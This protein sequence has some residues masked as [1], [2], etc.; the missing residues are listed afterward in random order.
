MVHAYNPSTQEVEVEGSVAQSQSHLYDEFKANLHLFFHFFN[1]I[2]LAFCLYVD[3]C[4]GA[5]SGVTDSGS[6]HV[7]AGN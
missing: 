6:C 5:G 7:G 1:F 3:L 4:R 2:L